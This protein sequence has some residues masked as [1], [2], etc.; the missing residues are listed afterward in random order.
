[1]LEAGADPDQTYQDGMTPLMY[2]ALNDNPGLVKAL[3]ERGAHRALTNKDGLTALDI[4]R[5][6]GHAEV[7][8][9]LRH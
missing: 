7:V 6:F 8:E 9:L 4:A 2:A 3:L 1:M 5:G